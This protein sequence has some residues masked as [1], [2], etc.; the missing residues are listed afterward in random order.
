MKES[1]MQMLSLDYLVWLFASDRAFCTLD[2]LQAYWQMPLSSDAQPFYTRVSFG[3]LLTP[4]P[5][6]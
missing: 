1:A 6:P 2:L 5:V 4:E 3:A